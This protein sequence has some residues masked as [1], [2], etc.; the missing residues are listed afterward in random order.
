MSASRVGIERRRF[1]WNKA[2]IHVS[3]SIAAVEINVAFYDPPDSLALFDDVAID[4]S[5]EQLG[6]AMFG[7]KERQIGR[8]ADDPISRRQRKR[9]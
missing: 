8:R 7:G 4:A 3:A 6:L 9:W 2:E 1:R 5:S